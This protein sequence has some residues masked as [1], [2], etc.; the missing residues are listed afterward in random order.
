MISSGV[1]LPS[2]IVNSPTVSVLVSSA[3][4][5]NANAKPSAASSTSD[6]STLDLKLTVRLS[7]VLVT[8]ATGASFAVSVSSASK[9]SVLVPTC[10]TVKLIVPSNP[11]VPPS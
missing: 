1:A 10:V 5:P 7:P 3:I 4:V 6:G 11:N 9:N 2:V 8:F